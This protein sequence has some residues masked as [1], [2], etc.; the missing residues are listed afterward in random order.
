MLTPSGVNY[1]VFNLMSFTSGLML[2]LS[3][4]FSTYRPVLA[5]NLLGIPVAAMGFDFGLCL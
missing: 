3:V 1:N 2:L 4:F 5:M